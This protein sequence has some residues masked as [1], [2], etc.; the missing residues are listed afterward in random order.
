MTGEYDMTESKNAT[1]EPQTSLT[2]MVRDTGAPTVAVVTKLE[3]EESVPH[4]IRNG[5]T[6]TLADVIAK[7]DPAT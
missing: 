2:V 4:T 3:T 7:G 6:V 5:E 1:L